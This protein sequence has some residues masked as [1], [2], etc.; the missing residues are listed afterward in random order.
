MVLFPD[1]G[2]DLGPAY[3]YAFL[4]ERVLAFCRETGVTCLDLRDTFARVHDRRSLWVSPFDHHP[5]AR[6][7][8]MAAV[9]ILEAFRAEWATR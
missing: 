1:F 4:H 8:E 6:A 3:P 9:R 7:N 2:E 5:S